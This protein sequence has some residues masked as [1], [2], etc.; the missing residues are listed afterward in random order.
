MSGADAI[1]FNNLERALSSDLNDVQSDAA[2]FLSEL[3]KYQLSTRVI[4]IQPEAIASVVLGGLTCSPSGADVSVGAGALAQN[5]ATLA[6]VPGPLDST[7][8]LARLD[9][10]II[11]PMPAPGLTTYYLIEA[12]MAEVIALSTLRD[13]YNPG[14]DTFVPTLLTKQIRRTIVTQLLVGGAN[15]PAPTGGN[16]VPLAIVRRPAGG[17]P[18]VATDIDDVRPIAEGGRQRPN[19]PIVES[20][21]LTAIEVAGSSAVTMLRVAMD[22][23]FGARSFELLAG[24]SIDPTSAPV[25]SPATVLAA[26]TWYY[27]YV[28]GWSLLQLR[29][30]FSDVSFGREGVL[31]LSHVAP[32]NART[33]AGPIALPAPYGVSLAPALTGYLVC[34]LRRNATNNGWQAMFSDDMEHF[35]LGSGVEV[36]PSTL[37]VAGANIVVPPAGALPTGYRDADLRVGYLGNTAVAGP[38]AANIRFLS[39]RD[40][41]SVV[42][43]DVLF[44][45]ALETSG[46]GTSL[47]RAKLPK[48]PATDTF[49]LLVS[50]GAIDAGSRVSIDLV[51]FSL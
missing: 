16:W 23:F 2:R 27:L 11:V 28:C 40:A 21:A 10:P 20:G 30:R 43:L 34:A 35:K 46:G 50:A 41:A 8:R 5:T 38:T 32:T 13:V 39:L 7:Y 44:G 36:Y 1:V 31:V 25:L 6:P 51:G 49:D 3:L 26:N 37:P 47:H 14:T 4:G 19:L 17:G 15:A 24:S 33:N 9:A 18:V 22:G 45:A 48:Q 12:Q 42:V 29:P